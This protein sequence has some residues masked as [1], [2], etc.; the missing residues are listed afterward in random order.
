MGQ[1]KGNRDDR[2]FLERTRTGRI[3]RMGIRSLHTNLSMV[4]QRVVLLR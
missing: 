4:R 1:V 2:V 3:Q